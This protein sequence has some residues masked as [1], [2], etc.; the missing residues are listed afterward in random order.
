MN[1]KLEPEEITDLADKIKNTLQSLTNID[2]I[3]KD[4]APNLE[5]ANVL[6]KSAD[7]A[8]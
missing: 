2:V 1:I 8:K 7:E 4:T 3:I 6:K 5:K